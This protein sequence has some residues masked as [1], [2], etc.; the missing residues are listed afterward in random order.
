[1][2]MKK[3]SGNELTKAHLRDIIRLAVDIQG[4]IDS[5]D[6]DLPGDLRHEVAAQAEEMEDIV[7]KVRNDLSMRAVFS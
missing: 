6:G 5:E 1:M 3:L 4:A 2:T 7:R